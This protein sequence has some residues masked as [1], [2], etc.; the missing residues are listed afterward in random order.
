MEFGP[1]RAVKDDTILS[2][3]LPRLGVRINDDLVYLGDLQYI[4]Q[5]T[6]HVEEFIYLRPSSLGHVTRL[7]LV[8]FE[9]F[10]DNKEG[11][12]PD[13]QGSTITL[14]DD[15]YQ[16]SLNLIDLPGYYKK[17]PSSNL[18]H[19]ADY[20][21]QR[22]Y[23]LTGDMVYQTFMRLVTED[24][25]DR[26]SV[27]CLERSNNPDLTPEMLEQSTDLHPV[28]LEHALENFSIVK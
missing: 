24:H 3:Y 20:V 14:A 10:L 2:P 15:T 16:Y 23:T 8:Q 6:Y 17:M 11:K 4:L 18:T 22:S 26:F 28:L 25:R 5:G 7:L 19:A 9:G 21:R 12:Y 13:P 27:H 1:I